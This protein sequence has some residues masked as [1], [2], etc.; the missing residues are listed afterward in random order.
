MASDRYSLK[1]FLSLGQV[2]IPEIQRD[3]VWQEK[4]VAKLLDSIIEDRKEQLK[5]ARQINAKE[6]EALPSEVQ[7]NF[8]R[9]L[10]KEITY[11]NIGF[12]Y[13][14]EDQAA[15]GVM[16]LIDGQQRLTTL[17]LLLLA[18]AVKAGE[19]EREYFRHHYF[20]QDS[21]RLDY[22][23]R[24]TS[25][26][27][28]AHFVKHILNEGS[29]SEVEDQFWYTQDLPNDV[30]VRM[31]LAN[32]RAIENFLM[33]NDLPFSFI[34]EHIEMWFFRVNQTA[35]GEELYLYMN[36]RGQSTRPHENIKAIFLGDIKD[37]VRKNEMGET[38]EVWQ[39]FFWQ[40]REEGEDEADPGFIEF[41][42][43][44]KI[45]QF[46]KQ[47]QDLSIPEMEKT[48]KDIY[49]SD[50][51][52]EQFL[53]WNDLVK[54]FNC[55]RKLGQ[56]DYLKE[57]WLQG[58]TSSTD[59]ITLL[60]FLFYA[61]EGPDAKD[62]DLKRTHRFFSNIA[63]NRSLNRNPFDSIVR[64]LKLMSLFITDENRDITDL[65]K[66][67]GEEFANLILT[68]EEVIKLSIFKERSSQRA[69]L[70]SAF[71]EA[72][73]F[74]YLNGQILVLLSASGVDPETSYFENFEL[75]RFQAH[76]E[77]FQ[78]VFQE[79]NDLLRRSLLVFGDFSRKYGNSPTLG[80]SRRTFGSD[81][82]T[83]REIIHDENKHPII[84]NL[85]NKIQEVKQTQQ[86][87]VEKALKVIVEKHLSESSETGQGW[88]YYF[89]NY[90]DL[91]SHC[92]YKAVCFA[93]SDLDEIYLLE[94]G[95]ARYS[96]SVSDK[97][98]ELNVG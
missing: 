28:L 71:W 17:Y 11:A 90:P 8:K 1:D 14:Y 2:V 50:Y 7:E 57:Q 89:I 74:K 23:V 65:T 61:T 5:R 34:E 38:W 26:L 52:D 9:Y 91:F 12:I 63:R 87:S 53:K 45:I 56:K 62:N 22:R 43:W 66:Y 78:A 39:K 29:A 94:L 25:H 40:H 80:G 37:P 77:V 42:R 44:I 93:G 3:Y 24:E 59:F 54:Y 82:R 75:D 79:P 97:L 58:N 68:K 31:I 67:Q 47:G 86:I 33:V 55:I 81:Q 95:D 69:E 21:P 19:K 73:D 30:T 32:Y 35:Q 27:F 18:A 48:V 72:E 85:L 84:R 13:G 49:A 10:S 96:T 98:K 51:F 83:W 64:C 36:S 41:L 88:K 15:N 70:E 16:H 20:F 46:V 6:L 92:Q 4:N 60:P 76:Y